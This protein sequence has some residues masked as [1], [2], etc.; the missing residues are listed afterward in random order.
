MTPLTEDIC[1]CG[2]SLKFIATPEGPHFGKLLCCNCGKFSKWVKNPNNLG[3]RETTKHNHIVENARWCS[4][5]GRTR[6]EIPRRQV[7][8]PH[9]S[10]PLEEGGK[11]EPENI[12]PLCTAC[13]K[14]AHWVRLYHFKHW[15][16]MEEDE[17][18]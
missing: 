5:C 2:G 12:V 8:E 13:H 14:L 10:I 11:D 4:F 15:K 17:E 6:Q 9:H 16:I 18:W 1:K 3:R 7:F